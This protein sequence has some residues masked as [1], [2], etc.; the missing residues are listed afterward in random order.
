MGDHAISQSGIENRD[1]F[2][3]AFARFGYSGG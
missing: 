3:V 2:I 1:D